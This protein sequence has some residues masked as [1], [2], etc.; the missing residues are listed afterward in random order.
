MFRCQ[1]PY[2]IPMNVFIIAF[3][4]LEFSVNVNYNS[5]PPPPNL[6]LQTQLLLHHLVSRFHLLSCQHPAAVW[7]SRLPHIHYQFRLETVV[8]CHVIFTQLF[9]N[10]SKLC[11]I[12]RLMI[13]FSEMYRKCYYINVTVNF[14]IQ[15][16]NLH[17]VYS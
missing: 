4:K 15:N 9:G 5:F 1:F 6:S 17:P 13:V 10:H 8:N 12:F 7:Y 14:Q 3:T 2:V 11:M 16:V